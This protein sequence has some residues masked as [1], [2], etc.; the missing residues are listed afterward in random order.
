[1][2]R[3]FWLLEFEDSWLVLDLLIEVLFDSVFS[4]LYEL[5]RVGNPVPINVIL[6]SL[7]NLSSVTVP[8]IILASGSTTD[9]IVCE[10]CSISFIDKSDPPVILNKTPYAPSIVCSSNGD[11]IAISAASIALSSPFPVPIAI[12]AG[13]AF[14]IIVVTSAK[15]R[16]ISPGTRISSAI[17]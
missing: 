13:P 5:F 17:D 1:M 3:S 12:Q 9:E 10:A 8:K 2:S 4:D 14:F 6:I 16:L 15:S 7:F 11:D